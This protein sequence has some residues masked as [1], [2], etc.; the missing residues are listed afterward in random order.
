MEGAG[1]RRP[2]GEAWHGK[3]KGGGAL[4]PVAKR[5]ALQ[6]MRWKWRQGEATDGAWRTQGGR[7]GR[8]GQAWR[9]AAA[10]NG[11]KKG[12]RVG[13]H[14]WQPLAPRT[15]PP[16]PPP[17]PCAPCRTSVH[18]VELPLPVSWY[19]FLHS[20][21]VTVALAVVLAGGGVTVQE[22]QLL[23]VHLV[24]H[25][26]CGRKEAVA[27]GRV[28]RRHG[29]KGGRGT[30]AAAAAKAAAAAAAVA[31]GCGCSS[32]RDRRSGPGPLQPPQPSV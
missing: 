27:A 3:V 28:G 11:G 21:H 4:T 18:A 12:G 17:P 9:I 14:G 32:S 22:E 13:G 24:R 23:G 19:W 10:S 25:L 26:P 1:Q 31:T 15:P 8:C 6:L 20:V 5:G 29:S 16:P 2:S 7:A 30:A